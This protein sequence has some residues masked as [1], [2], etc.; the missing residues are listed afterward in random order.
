[1]PEKPE[2]VFGKANFCHCAGQLLL[3]LVFKIIPHPQMTFTHPPLPVM[4]NLPV[5]C[6]ALELN[7]VQL[8]PQGDGNPS[9]KG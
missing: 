5:S 9:F 7:W 8:D 4:C 2:K 6:E 1:M 3:Y